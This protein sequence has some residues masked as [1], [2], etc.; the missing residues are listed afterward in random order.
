MKI[1]KT[2]FTIIII[3]ILAVDSFASPNG[4]ATAKETEI[5]FMAKKAYEDGFYEVSLG[6]LERFQKE[7][8]GST[9]AMEAR[10]LT[11]ECYF[12]QGRYL[13]ALNIIE[14]LLNEPGSKDFRDAVYFW[15]GEVHFKGNN[16]EK[17]AAFYESVIKD[18]PQSFY[19]PAAYYSLGW[20]FSL[21]GKYSQ[22]L[23]A[24]ELLRGKFPKEPQSKDAAFKII[25]C[26]YNLKEYSDLRN[27]IKPYFKLY[28]DDALRLSYLYFYLAESDYYLN[29][30]EEAAGSYLKSSQV[31]GDDKVRGLVHLGLAWSYLKLKR[32]KE[33]EEV[34]ADIKQSG[35]DKKSMD[36]LLLGQAVLMFQTNRVYESKKIYDQII[37]VS[38]DPLILV[39]AYL[40]KADTLYNL[41]E[42]SGAA[43]VYK[44]GLD[45]TDKDSGKAGVPA[46]LINKL[47]H[48][49]ILAYIKQGQLQPAIEE[50]KNF[51]GKSPDQEAR[52]G[53]FSQI[54]DAYQDS[55]EFAKAEE[56]YANILKDYPNSSYGDY[57]Q[58]QLGVAQLK[59][60]DLMAAIASFKLMIKNYAQSRL[61]DDAVYS[62]GLAYFQKGDYIAACD[63]FTKFQSEFKDSPLAA[64]ALYML[65]VCFLNLG[66]P[67]EALFVFKDI[68]RQNP[69]DTEL[70][71]K[72]E[73]EIADCYYKLGQEK[74]AVKRFELLR[75]RYPDSKIT[76]EVMWWLGQYYYR[77][78]DLNLAGRYFSSL[79]RD[80]PGSN[81]AG[82][83][84]YALGLTFNEEGKLAQAADNFKMAV[85]LGNAGIRGQAAIALGDLY[86]REGKFEE[87]LAKY[88]EIIRDNPDIGKLLFP[89]I[90]QAYY[91]VGDYDGAKLF[92][93]KSLAAADVKEAHGIRFGLA[94]AL[95]AKSD[96]DAA[97]QQYL[98]AA[99][100]YTEQGELFSRA[101][102]R[103]A[104]LYEDKE[105]FKEALKIYRRIIQKG[106]PEAEFA[107]E[108]IDWIRANV[109]VKDPAS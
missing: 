85:K 44:E 28:A 12:Y 24:F 47:R 27:R 86:C 45:K 43:K 20:S 36:I 56:T 19:T 41:A 78:D 82:D 88:K 65:G 35:L 48:N 72:A 59:K 21:L 106:A 23:Q 61:L 107:Q 58:Y 54:G 102:L 5:L 63:I 87:A 62:L 99:S 95:E 90:A 37:S 79:A 98:L 46:E 64:K 103:A 1:V 2:G 13:E 57:V 93:S 49:L 42:Y 32:Y 96:F 76:P 26:L 3:L 40:G 34:F 17:A 94:E 50:L 68:S 25:E 108:R 100:L 22:A 97:I 83:A 104:K 31:T 51:A 6:M 101:L 73:Y 7:F 33:A 105:N 84:F 70:L 91:K 9:K 16:Y 81:L 92:Y 11:G 52:V 4:S 38:S 66:K 30:L 15:I 60:A 14:G 10:L 77:H 80:F 71:Q 69:Q 74:E 39:Q 18:F 89:R 8:P 109:R 67:N 75:A 29:N 53:A 55:G